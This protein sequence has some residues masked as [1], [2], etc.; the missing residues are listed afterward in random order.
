MRRREIECVCVVYTLHLH[1]GI[2]GLG[3]A[4]R[5][6][7]PNASRDFSHNSGEGRAREEIYVCIFVCLVKRGEIKHI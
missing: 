6:G 1:R 7:S 5:G 2:R 4:E 3:D